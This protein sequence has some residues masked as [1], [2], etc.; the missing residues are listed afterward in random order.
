MTIAS[1]GYSGNGNLILDT[2]LAQMAEAFSAPPVV[3][4]GCAV[5]VTSAV[6]RTVHVAGGVLQGWAIRDTVPDGEPDLTLDSQTGTT[7]RWDA[8][9]AH[10]NWQATPAGET[11]L[12]VV[13]GALTS[14]APIYPATLAATPGT[15]A[16]QVLA[17]VPVTQTGAGTPL[18]VT[19]ASGGAPLYWNRDD[20]TAMDPAQL[21]YGATVVQFHPAGVQNDLLIRRGA[22]GS[23]VFDSLN[24][25]GWVDINLTG[26]NSAPSGSRKPQCRAIG[27]DLELSGTVVRADKTW[28]TQGGGNDGDWDI[29]DVPADMAPET[30][31]VAASAS[32]VSVT[33]TVGN[34]AR[35]DGRR[36]Y[37]TVSLGD[38][39]QIN[40]DGIRVRIGKAS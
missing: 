31:R 35:N 33:I 22:P 26:G 24:N 18:N 37:A 3:E 4:S 10:R 21:P 20:A 38:A 6:D 27:G 8:I 23:E 7:P 9:V 39:P 34:S 14:A 11:T 1:T 5:T 19:Y 16:D 25:P 28:F 29:G 32:R 17:L 13:K 36:I 12:A 30:A 15:T 2:E 40:L